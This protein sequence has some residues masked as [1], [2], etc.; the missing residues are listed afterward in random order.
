MRKTLK[1]KILISATKTYPKLILN[2]L[3]RKKKVTLSTL[4]HLL[5]LSYRIVGENEI[6]AARHVLRLCNKNKIY[7]KF[8]YAVASGLDVSSKHLLSELSKTEQ[9]LK[10]KS[11]MN[12]RIS[13]IEN[14]KRNTY[15]E[16]VS[17]L[18]ILL[19]F[20]TFLSFIVP[21]TF[22]FTSLFLL[23]DS[24]DVL[25]YFILFYPIFIS[26]FLRLAKVENQ[27]IIK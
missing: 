5:Y 26:L 1:L 4:Q 23:K 2:R 20:F 7:K 3:N 11:S 19:T 16:S 9:Y 17:R 14:Y 24:I 6:H 27:S 10:L 15:L 18:R 21:F 13:F 8:L 25:S 22:L 12:Q